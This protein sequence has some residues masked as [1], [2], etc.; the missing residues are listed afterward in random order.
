M[1][2][3]LLYKINLFCLIFILQI[4]LSDNIYS[5]WEEGIP[6]PKAKSGT[7]ATTIND[8]IYVLGGKGIIGTSPLSEIYDFK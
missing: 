5:K 6:L 8:N 2:V 4:F 1:F 3:R 7:V